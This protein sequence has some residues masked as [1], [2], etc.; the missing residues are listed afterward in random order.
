MLHVLSNSWALLLGMGLIMLGNGLQGT[1]L[2]VRATLEGF[3]TTVIGIVM[4]GYF[5]GLILGCGL[6][7]KMVARVGH[8]RIFGALASLASTSILIQALFVEPWLWWMMRLVTGFSFAGIYIV[9]ESWLNDASENESRGQLLSIYMVIS[10][11]GMAGGQILLNVASPSSYEL[12]VLVS[13]LVSLA[14]IPIL[15]SVSKAPSFDMPESVSLIQLFKV[16]PLGIFGM[17]FN[18]LTSGAIFGMGAVYATEIGLSVQAVSFFMVAINIGGFVFQYPLGWIS[19]RTGRRRVIIFSCIGGSAIS[20]F[21][22]TYSEQGLV[23]FAIVALIGGLSIPLYSLCSAI[24]NDYLTPKQMV[25]ASGTLVLANAI[26]ATLG[27]PLTALTMDIW[28][29]NAF[30][31]SIGGIMGTIAIFALWRV[32]QREDVPAEERGDFVVMTSSP[33]GAS[34]TPDLDLEVIVEAAAENAEEVRTSFEELAKELQ[35]SDEDSP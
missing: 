12:F 22:M 15:V 19:D 3:D 2:G 27:S 21:A 18:G 14:V 31:G 24:T 23:L 29:V 34:L 13:L 32:T 26:G 1:L 35:A 6:V 5:M 25:A 17:L 33:L 11:G 7:P 16:S 30:Y 8:I 10:V 20:F 4:S 9:A 28:G